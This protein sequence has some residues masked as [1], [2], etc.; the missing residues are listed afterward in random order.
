MSKLIELAKRYSFSIAD[1]VYMLVGTFI[2]AVAFQLFLLPNNIVSGGVTGLSIVFSDL[3]GWSPVFIQYLFNI[4]LLLVAYIFLGK[5]AGNRTILAS[6]IL[7]LFI[8]LIGNWQPATTDIFLATVIG[9]IV[10]GIGLGIVFR[11]KASTGG[12]SILAQILNKYTG[13]SL[14]ATTMLSDGLVILL[15]LTTFQVNTV[16]YGFINLYITTRSIDMTQVGIRSHKNVLIISKESDSIKKLIMNTINR[17]VTNIGIRGGMANQNRDMLMCVI[18]EREFPYL[19]EMIL[20]Y[21][22]EAFVVVMSA[23]EV[24][25]RGFS[26]ANKFESYGNSQF[27]EEVVDSKE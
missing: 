7:P 18:P 6:L 22:E 2:V 1:Y 3:L 11:A 21:D 23:S 9:G 12:T 27:V 19:K 10:N 8:S 4:P 20:Q 24:M 16:L 15:S 25:G 13:L 26:L 14:G 17:G 5:E